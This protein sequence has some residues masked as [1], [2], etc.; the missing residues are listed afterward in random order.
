M[1]HCETFK[2][3]DEMKPLYRLCILMAAA[4]ISAAC[5]ET[6]VIEPLPEEESP[7]A[8]TGP[9]TI[10][11]TEVTLEGSYAYDGT[12]NVR[13][14]FRYAKTQ[15]E[16]AVAETIPAVM[17]GPDS[18]YLVIPNVAN[19]D[20]WYRSVVETGPETHMGKAGFFKINFNSVPSVT[21]L[22]AEITDDTYVLKG[23]YAFE[24]KKIPV[25]PGFFY[26][27]SEDGLETAS[28][29]TANADG[30]NFSYE[31][32]MSFGEQCFYQAA[33][34]VSGEYYRGAVRSAG[35]TNLSAGGPANCF[36]V[37]EPGLYVFEAVR[38]DGVKVDGDMADWLWC[39]GEDEILS[40]IKY[41][42]GKI[43]FSA[44]EQKGS[45]II[46][47]VK[48]GTVQ[49]SWHV[50]VTE[51]KEQSYG[52]ITMHDRNLGALGNDAASADAIGLMYQW[53]R[54]DPFIGTNVMDKTIPVGLTESVGFGLGP[55][56]RV[57]TAPY[58]YNADMVAKGWALE[59]VRCDETQ[60]MR[61]PMTFYGD[62]NSGNW[63][64]DNNT[65]K[66]Y[67]GGVSLS[68]TLNNPCPAGWR[69]PTHGEMVS[70][71]NG[72]V[73]DGNSE[74]AN[75]SMTWGRRVVY[76]GET[77]NFPATGWREWHCALIRPGNVIAMNT[78]TLAAA[79]CRVSI[80]WDFNTGPGSNLT[81]QAFP[82]RC[83]K[84]E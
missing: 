17:A 79:E 2:N 62:W 29:V 70:Y 7:V 39:T 61:N 53:G 52:G 49:W 42:D 65:V 63:A 1:I 5:N 40:D 15:T 46:A 84:M 35:V 23:S 68:N 59:Q 13:A 34:L 55:A 77:W 81:C 4:M 11:E 67:W 58:V 38:S 32:P 22:S 47:L 72:L 37:S 41:V 12:G 20:Y 76:N 80:Y 83:I 26:A 21:T 64:A 82:V 45:E 9:A 14:G 50:W 69:V 56:E 73:N 6:I 78:A 25:V 51:M 33:A 57:W 43:M 60:A 30:K 44:G 36:I 54:K 3:Y 8:K 48:G 10:D 31:V 75:Y 71:I 74:Y 24:S 19:G 28:F 18:F 16:L 66:D 27:A